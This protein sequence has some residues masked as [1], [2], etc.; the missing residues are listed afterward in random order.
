MHHRVCVVVLMLL[1][2]VAGAYGQAEDVADIP[3]QD[4]RV[5]GDENKRYFLIGPKRGAREP[6]E[7]YGLVVVMPGGSGTAD[8]HPFVKRIYKHALP[9]RYLVAQPVAVKWTPGQ[10]IVWPTR[11]HPVP[12]QEFSTEEFVEAVVKDVQEEHTVDERFIFTLTWSSSGPAAYAISLQEGT[13]ITGSF[14]AMS[15]FKPDQLPPL[16]RA[17]GRPYYLYHSPEDKVCP[18]RMAEAARDALAGYGA[19][20]QLVTYRGGHGWRGNVYGNIKRGIRWLERSALSR[21]VTKKGQ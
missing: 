5:G 3:S 18:F 17:E 21:A 9:E 7:G 19:R 6:R 11:T 10:R 13:P 16:K 2:V 1:A 12:K 8:F 15:V 4:L 20:V 14:I